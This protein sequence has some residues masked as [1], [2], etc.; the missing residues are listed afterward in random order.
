MTDEWIGAERQHRHFQISNVY[1]QDYNI[2][3]DAV[4]LIEDKIDNTSIMNLKNMHHFEYIL[5]EAYRESEDDIVRFLGN[6]QYEVM[7]SSIYDWLYIVGPKKTHDLRQFATAFDIKIDKNPAHKDILE[8]TI[9]PVT[10]RRKYILGKNFLRAFKEPNFSL[11]ALIVRM[12][13]ISG[14]ELD[15][16]MSVT[17]YTQPEL[18]FTLETQLEYFKRHNITDTCAASIASVCK[19]IITGPK[20]IELLY[21]L[22]YEGLIN[23]PPEPAARQFRLYYDMQDKDWRRFL[24]VFYSHFDEFRTIPECRAHFII[25]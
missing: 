7:H 20:V 21:A 3:P 25:H 22:D 5:N 6:C 9:S 11:N 14:V 2:V 8:C 19:D 10:G 12:K 17:D 13:A 1:D 4:Q 18:Q 23:L 24:R 16:F 15:E